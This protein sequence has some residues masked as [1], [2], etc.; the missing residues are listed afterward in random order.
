MRKRRQT[1]PGRRG[2][3]VPASR[4]VLLLTRQRCAVA[5]DKK[6]RMELKA[7]A[8]PAKGP[9]KAGGAK[10]GAKAPSNWMKA[11]RRSLVIG[12]LLGS[13]VIGGVL[14]NWAL[15]VVDDG[16]ERPTWSVPGKVQS[17]PL[18]VWEGE[19]LSPEVL[20]VDLAAAGYARVP[21]AVQPGDFQVTD[22]AVHVVLAPA[23]GPGWAVKAGESLVTFAGGRVT[24]ITPSSQLQL[25]PATLAVVR[26]A[27]NESRSPVPLD[28]IPKHMIQA[29]LAIEDTRFYEHMG[30]DP[31]GIGRAM[32]HNAANGAWVQ[33][34]STLTQQLVKNLFLTHERTADRKVREALLSLAIEKRK[35]KDE[36]LALYLNEIYL[37]QAGGSSLCG[38]DA[39]A[40]AFFAKPIDRVSL[41]EAA[42][43]AG[44]IQSPNP[45]NPVRHPDDALARRNVVL[46]RMAVVG[47]I[48]A[49]TA[50]S[51]RQAPLGAHASARG[52]VSPW[53]VDLVVETVEAKDEGRV[54]R[55]ALVLETTIQPQVQRLAEAALTAGLAEVIAAHPKLS[56]VQG[57]V[58]AVR[59][60]DGAVVAM[61]GGRDYAD[62]A[63]NRVVNSPRQVGSTVKP[64]TMLAAFEAEP[65]LSPATV[66]TDAAIERM[67]DGK[68]WTPTN[69][70]QAW[71]GEVSLRSAM[72]KSRNIPAVLL[73]ERVGLPALQG[74]LA[75]LGLSRATAF[76]SA[77]LGGFSATPRELAGAYTVFA[78]DGAY[79]EPYLLRSV[80][81]DDRVVE[82][83]A[84]AKASVRYSERA[85]FL[86]YDVLRSVMTDGTGAGAANYGVGPG[87]AGKTGTTD[88]Y[89]DAWF[90]GVSGPYAV[91]VWVGYDH[92]KSLG[93]TGGA[94]ALPIWA[95]FVDAV[96]FD[97]KERK[98]PAGLVSAE[99]CVATGAPPCP[100]C[101]ETGT[102]WFTEGTVPVAACGVVPDPVEEAKGGW[103]RIGELF[104]LRG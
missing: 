2:K 99:V 88:D 44:I 75:K 82:D 38:I 53:A 42:T 20:A 7:G 69:Y 45:Y 104:G 81:S 85:T 33:G 18:V 43:I 34:G 101:S 49:A 67:V 55:E 56:G 59:A 66:F 24:S 47:F 63:F 78:A 28:R 9:S 70:D 16:L 80:R 77:A 37:G 26:G 5:K 93:L 71:S 22:D 79:H 27:D 48:D 83:H 14:W 3:R 97:G 46:A 68:V 54:S 98:A 50:E 103:G 41:A 76:P 12:T 58:I 74:H 100:A 35:S 90:A 13:V 8:K 32:A 15:G 92:P 10:K 86:A 61:V 89:S 95:R 17:A 36:I 11:V 102:D 60:R 23:T 73:A 29:V 94:V 62:S 52:R 19:T 31:I 65:A 40:Q 87:A 39:A 91:V 57:A 6:T 64:L 1:G 21:H 51:A 72:A 4:L 25:P 96:G 30:I 84:P